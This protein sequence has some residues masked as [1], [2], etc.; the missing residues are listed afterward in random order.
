MDEIFPRYT[1]IMFNLK[2]RCWINLSYDFQP[3]GPSSLAVP[4]DVKRSALEFSHS[5]LKLF[6]FQSDEKSNDIYP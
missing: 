4:K 6:Y 5:F 3:V 2:T 1:E